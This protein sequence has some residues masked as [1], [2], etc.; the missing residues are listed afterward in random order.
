MSGPGDQ[1]STRREA[2]N[3]EDAGS[4]GPVRRYLLTPQEAA[5]SL[6]VGRTTVFRLLRTG[7]LA[8]VLIGGC[9][10][11]PVTAIEDYLRTITP[12]PARPVIPPLDGQVLASNTIDGHSGVH[13]RSARRERDQATGGLVSSRVDRPTVVVVP[14][15]FATEELPVARNATPSAG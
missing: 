12:G 7:D 14:L 4:Y 2:A 6:G 9:R 8:S 5:Q 1:A 15:P 11:I 3:A 13:R 10:R